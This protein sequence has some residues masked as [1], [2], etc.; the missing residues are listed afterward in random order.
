LFWAYAVSHPGLCSRHQQKRPNCQKCSY[1]QHVPL[2][3]I[4]CSLNSCKGM[5]WGWRGTSGIMMV[6]TKGRGCN[7]ECANEQ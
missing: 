3:I 4:I 6:S 7:Q 2:S 5:P 1:S